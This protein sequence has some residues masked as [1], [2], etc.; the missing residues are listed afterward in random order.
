M[1]INLSRQW[2]HAVYLF[3]RSQSRQHT[4][5]WASIARPMPPI[6]VFSKHA[7]W[8]DEK[9]VQQSARSFSSSERR[10]RPNRDRTIDDI[11]VR[12]R[13]VI[14]KKGMQSVFEWL[15]GR[16]SVRI[17][18]M[19]GTDQMGGC[20]SM[21]W[22]MLFVT[23]HHKLS[24]ITFSFLLFFLPFLGYMLRVKVYQ[25]STCIQCRI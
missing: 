11:P 5:H 15:T 20:F 18:I 14:A 23:C 9:N 22:R 2:L 8:N 25:L 17:F 19:V 7:G 6:F 13:A 3:Y 21:F 10:F 12:W 16:F 1:C 4:T 24:R